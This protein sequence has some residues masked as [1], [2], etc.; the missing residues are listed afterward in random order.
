MAATASLMKASQELAKKS[1][2]VRRRTVSRDRMKAETHK[3]LENV[4][5]SVETNKMLMASVRS[6]ST[7]RNASATRRSTSATRRS[8]ALNQLQNISSLEAS[9]LSAEVAEITSRMESATVHS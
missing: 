3:E 4:E 7:T 9:D 5:S 1:P 6:G 8:S 2:L